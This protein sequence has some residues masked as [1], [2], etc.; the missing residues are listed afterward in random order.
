M[1]RAPSQAPRIVIAPADAL[2][3]EPV[4]IRIHGCAPRAQITL[5]ATAWDDFGREWMSWAAF[6]TD[7][8][9]SVDVGS[10]AP[11]A[12]S[13]TT[14][15]AMGLLWS[16][17]LDPSKRQDVSLFAMI[18]LEPMTI[19]LTGIAEG[20]QFGSASLTRRFLSHSVRRSSVRERGLVGTLFMPIGE[21]V[22]PG[23]LVLGGSGGGL[24]EHQAALLAA[25]A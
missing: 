2:A 21:G 23:V 5:R 13:Y 6:E 17:R 22:Y 15:D 7:A 10:Q 9:G 8:D 4:R 14:A 12:G 16:M 20:N 19:T 18:D 24:R 3:D 11:V 25:H 1:A